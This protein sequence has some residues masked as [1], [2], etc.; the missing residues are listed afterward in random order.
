MTTRK[1]IFISIIILIGI[2]FALIM[3]L[4]GFKSEKKDFNNGICPNCK[5][6][7]N[8]FTNDSQGGRGYICDN[9]K[10]CTWVSYPRIDKNFNKGED[11]N[12]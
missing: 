10:Y 3:F 5:R 12:D 1:I 6:K 8:H 9:C 7:L 11:L 4:I 2:I